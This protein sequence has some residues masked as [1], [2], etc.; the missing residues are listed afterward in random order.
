MSIRYL[1]LLAIPCLCVLFAACESKQSTPL[2]SPSPGGSPPASG[3]SVPAG[4][5][6][7]ADQ[8]KSLGQ[9]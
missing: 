2:A 9:Q 3:G 6:Q 7:G 1:R 8:I 5:G 4:S